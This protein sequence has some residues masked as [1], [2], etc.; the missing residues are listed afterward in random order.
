VCGNL[1]RPSS[2]MVES[3]WDTGLAVSIAIL[4]SVAFVGGSAAACVSLLVLLAEGGLGCDGDFS[5]GG[6]SARVLSHVWSGWN[7]SR[8]GL[9][10]DSRESIWHLMRPTFN[11]VELGQGRVFSRGRGLHQ[12]SCVPSRSC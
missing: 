3:R 10:R 11:E 1:A 5:R 8:S 9:L 7:S 4:S 2:E 12:M 6:V